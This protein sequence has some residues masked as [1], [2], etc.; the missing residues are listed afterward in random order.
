M[1]L[2]TRAVRRSVTGEKPGIHRAATGNLPENSTKGISDRFF[3]IFGGLFWGLL[4]FFQ[5][6]LSMTEQN[7]S[8]CH[9]GP[10][11]STVNP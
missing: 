7:H 1:V 6:N 4:G 2:S 8:Q 5:K 3:G 9:V 11:S 10:E